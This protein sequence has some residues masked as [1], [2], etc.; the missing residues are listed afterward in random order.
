MSWQE[1][2]QLIG[3]EDANFRSRILKFEKF[4]DSCQAKFLTS[5]KFLTCY[6]YSVIL[7]LRI[8]KYSLAFTFLMY[9]V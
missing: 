4:P 3:I 5:A 6:C 9:V 1:S 2:N 8:E 7:L